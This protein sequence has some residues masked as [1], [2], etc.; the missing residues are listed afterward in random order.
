MEY[1]KLCM[2][3][4]L[5]TPPIRQI[6]STPGPQ[7]DPIGAAQRRARGTG[8]EHIAAGIRAAVRPGQITL[9]ATLA[10]TQEVPSAAPAFTARGESVPIVQA[11]TT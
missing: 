7:S 6:R 10:P 1:A 2:S 4:R 11:R 8:P 5:A 9:R 3:M